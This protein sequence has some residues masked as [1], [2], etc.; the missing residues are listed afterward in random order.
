MEVAKFLKLLNTPEAP[1]SPSQTEELERILHEYP[2]FQTARALHLR[3]LK[4]LDS[5]RYN[6][7]LKLTAA[8]TVSRE[9][10][11]D[12]ITSDVFH[13]DKVAKSLLGQSLLP[14]DQ[15][16]QAEIVEAKTDTLLM[17]GDPDDDSPLPQSKEDAS[18][19]LNPNLFEK[20]IAFSLDDLSIK[21]E[22]PELGRPLHFTQE[23][24]HSFSEWL[25]LTKLKPI[26]PERNTKLKEEPS[27]NDK[28][29]KFELLD[30]FLE[31]NPK[32]VPKPDEVT[33]IDIEA[34]TTLDT[35]TLMTETLA[36]VYLEQKKYK[37][38]LQAYKILSLKYPEKSSFFADR[39]KTIKKL[40]K[41]YK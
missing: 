1:I 40:H 33:S 36:R 21:K 29:R 17:F 27:K 13:Q 18:A 12:Y 2:Y 24:R 10:L 16:I 7:H 20:E 38:A 3:A 28:N 11:F 35:Q 15:P 23:E 5:Y 6:D 8:H 9:V 25:Q 22:I 39:I 34:S 19:I 31:N 30:K 14:D 37:K 26:A 4:N 41:K 32:I